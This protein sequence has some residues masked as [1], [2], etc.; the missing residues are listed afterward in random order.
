MDFLKANNFFRHFS[1]IMY[2]KT[3]K[4]R[5]VLRRRKKNYRFCVE[6]IENRC[7]LPNKRILNSLS[8][9]DFNFLNIDNNPMVT[10]VVLLFFVN[11]STLIESSRYTLKSAWKKI[12]RHIQESNAPIFCKLSAAIALFSDQVLQLEALPRLV[13]NTYIIK[14]CNT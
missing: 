9:L 2:M 8:G 13:C 10:A 11:S 1:M 4:S 7:Y 6:N 3:E 5:Q 14:K 12:A